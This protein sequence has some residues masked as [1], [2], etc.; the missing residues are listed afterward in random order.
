MTASTA[1]RGEKAY[2]RYARRSMQ[3]PKLYIFPHRGKRPDEVRRFQRTAALFFFPDSASHRPFFAT[4]AACLSPAVDYPAAAAY[5]VFARPFCK[6]PPSSPVLSP[7]PSSFLYAPVCRESLFP[8]GSFFAFCYAPGNP[9][10]Y[11]IF[12]PYRATIPI[13]S[14]YVAPARTSQ[15]RGIP[16]L[17]HKWRTPFHIPYNERIPLLL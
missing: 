1:E 9:P 15:V 8:T 2:K 7:P 14:L 16:I 17:Q 3:A 12:L 5:R 4:S 13:P 10:P 6:R 11:L